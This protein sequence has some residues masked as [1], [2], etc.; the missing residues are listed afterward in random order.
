MIVVE[1]GAADRDAYAEYTLYGLEETIGA[2]RS[3]ADLYEFPFYYLYRQSIPPPPGQRTPNRPSGWNAVMNGSAESPPA[4]LMA[5]NQSLRRLVLLDF[6]DDHV[7]VRMFD[8]IPTFESSLHIG[9]IRIG[10]DQNRFEF[11]FQLR[12][13]RDWCLLRRHLPAY[14]S[15]FS[16]VDS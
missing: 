11:S 3:K 5:R 4:A 8:P 12:F 13:G 15:G 16:A 6:G 1:F 10:P 14:L 7:P 9:A 2:G